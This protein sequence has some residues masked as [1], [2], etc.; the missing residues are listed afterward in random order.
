MITEQDRDGQNIVRYSEVFESIEKIRE[1]FPSTPFPEAL[2]GL[3]PRHRE[4][5]MIVKAKNVDITKTS[6]PGV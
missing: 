6:V 2:V 4:G 5:E 3:F 1:A